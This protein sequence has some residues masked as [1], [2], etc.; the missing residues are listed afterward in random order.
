M[1]K[2]KGERS[3]YLSKRFY[4][5]IDSLICPCGAAKLAR[6]REYILKSD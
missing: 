2:V 6:E 4:V 5:N 3:T 1:I